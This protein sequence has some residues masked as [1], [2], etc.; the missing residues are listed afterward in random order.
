[1]SESLSFAWM[2]SSSSHAAM[3][4]ASKLLCRLVVTRT[5]KPLLDATPQIEHVQMWS[6]IVRNAH[7]DER[8]QKLLAQLDQLQREST[9]QSTQ[10]DHVQE[11]IKELEA[12]V[13]KRPAQQLQQAFPYGATIQDV[14]SAVNPRQ[15]PIRMGVV[16]YGLNIL[17]MVLLASSASG[18]LLVDQ[19]RL[20]D[21]YNSLPARLAAE[22][23]LFTDSLTSEDDIWPIQTPSQK[24]PANLEYAHG[25]YS[26][27]GG[28]K[29]QEFYA[30]APN[31][32]ANMAV[33]MTVRQIGSSDYD[34]L[35]MVARVRRTSSGDTDNITFSISLTHGNWSLYHYQP[36]HRNSYDNWK[37]LDG[38]DSNAIHRG[39][40]AVNHLLLVVRSNEYQCYINGHIVGRDI[41]SSMSPSTYGYAGL[42]I[43]DLSTTAVFNDFAVFP[44]PPPY[45]PLLHGL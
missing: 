6:P 20:A 33:S 26:M 21:Y 9:G 29:G 45:Q 25:G 30:W 16:F 4:N 37:Y 3:H 12:D 34:G 39:P 7:S 43:N 41:D 32:F 31:M 42:Y 5:G 36:G 1:M 28:P 35:G 23:P 2:D 27:S 8:R 17:L 24:Y 19:R 44:A 14:A 38:G 18:T 15:R 10:H 11:Y 13:F 40:N 22:T